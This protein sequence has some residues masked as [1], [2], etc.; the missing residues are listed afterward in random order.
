MN[1]EI[2]QVDSK[3]TIQVGSF[4]I[5]SK[6]NQ[7]LREVLYQLLFCKVTSKSQLPS[8]IIALHF[9]LSYV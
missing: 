8:G 3:S 9:Y 6:G 5:D 2:D 1:W 4:R 7:G